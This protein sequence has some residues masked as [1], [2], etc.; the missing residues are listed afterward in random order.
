MSSGS[1]YPPRKSSSKS[2][3][4]SNVDQ[5]SNNEWV[6]QNVITSTSDKITIKRIVAPPLLRTVSAG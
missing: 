5:A 1:K 4:V 6:A 3:S 2:D